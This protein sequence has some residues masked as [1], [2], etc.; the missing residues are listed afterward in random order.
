MPIVVEPEAGTD[1]GMLPEVAEFLRGSLLKGVIGGR[2]VAASD[3]ETFMTLD[4]GTGEPIAEV[5]AMKPPEADLAG[6]AGAKAFTSTGWS[7][8]P[9]NERAIW[10]HRL[11]GASARPQPTHRPNAKKGAGKN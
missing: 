2:D 3:G 7:T 5:A 11:L 4:P 10:I 8:M 9:A 1:T 6:R